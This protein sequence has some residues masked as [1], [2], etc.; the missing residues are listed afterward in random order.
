VDPRGLYQGQYS[1]IFIED[2]DDHQ[3]VLSGSLQMIQ[4]RERVA[5]IPDG[6]AA[7]QWYLKRLEE[8]T[9]INHMKLSK[10]KSKVHPLSGKK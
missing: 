2:Q 5:D 6:C 9:E 1:N 8:Y 7:I 10:G 3:S 4:N